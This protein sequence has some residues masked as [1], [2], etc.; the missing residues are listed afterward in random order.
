MLRFPRITKE[1]VNSRVNF[2]GIVSASLEV[3]LGMRPLLSLHSPPL[4]FVDF[5]FALGREVTIAMQLT[6][7]MLLPSRQFSHIFQSSLQSRLLGV[8]LGLGLTITGLCSTVAHAA[9]VSNFKASL[10]MHSL[11]APTAVNTVVTKRSDVLLASEFPANGVYLYGQSPNRDQLGRAYLVFEV[12]KD[13]VVG[14][15]YMPNSSF[16]CF[17]GNLTANKLALTVIDT[18]DRTP[19]PYAIS[20]APNGQVASSSSSAPSLSLVGYHR[21]SSLSDNDQRILNICKADLQK[22]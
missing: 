11:A 5:P 15:F 18:Y 9:D 20:L 10:A 13:R 14:A 4:Q 8:A 22:S 19:H 16:D 1:L 12:S 21:I 7:S 3:S 2:S 6:Q 17:F